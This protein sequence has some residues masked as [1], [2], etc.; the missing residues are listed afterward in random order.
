MITPAE[1]ADPLLARFLEGGYLVG[2]S[3]FREPPEWFDA[4]RAA[5]QP[6]VM[7]ALNWTDDPDL[8]AHVRYD[9]CETECP[10][11]IDTC[12]LFTCR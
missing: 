5:G 1:R 2:S 8:V 9:E 3:F 7:F 10:H 11:A 4:A 6:V 12:G